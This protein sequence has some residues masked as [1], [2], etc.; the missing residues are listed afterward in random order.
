MKHMNVPFRLD[1]LLGL[2]KK[3]QRR[4]RDLRSDNYISNNR[5]RTITCIFRASNNTGIQRMKNQSTGDEQQLNECY[6][7]SVEGRSYPVEIYHTSEPVPDY[8][9]SMC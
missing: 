9:K 7:L 4:R 5:Q 3:I 1:L 2:L 8:R 6:I